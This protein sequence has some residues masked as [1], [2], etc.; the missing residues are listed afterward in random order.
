M[1][2][3]TGF[4]G[5]DDDL[6]EVPT[7]D[8]APGPSTAVNV[9]DDATEYAIVRFNNKVKPVDK[10]Y[11]DAANLV[12]Q[13]QGNWGRTNVTLLNKTTYAF[14]LTCSSCN[15]EFSYANPSNFWKTHS[16]TCTLTLTPSP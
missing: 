2:Q 13:S 1:S 16:T 3:A 11:K 7:D 5:E 4:L 10:A 9:F 6:T 14:K 8:D 12:E 15:K